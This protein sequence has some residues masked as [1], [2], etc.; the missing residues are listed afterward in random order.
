MA[1]EYIRSTR[2]HL[3]FLV[4]VT[5]VL[6]YQVFY[7]Q[8]NQ[9]KTLSSNHKEAMQTLNPYASRLPTVVDSG[10]TSDTIIGWGNPAQRTTECPDINEAKAY[11]A[12]Q[13]MDYYSTFLG[14][15]EPPVFYDIGDVQK[16]RDTRHRSQSKTGISADPSGGP[17][18]SYI[19]RKVPVTDEQGNVTEKVEYIRCPSSKHIEKDNKCILPPPGHR[20][21]MRNWNADTNAMH[22]ISG[23][24]GDEDLLEQSGNFGSY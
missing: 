24:Q 6:L 13:G 11:L 5:L 18:F 4:L 3:T 17:Q 7:V 1:E 19:Y 22:K 20:E 21:P 16:T 10:L 9:L 15:H 14:G 8:R 2:H 12:L 23:F